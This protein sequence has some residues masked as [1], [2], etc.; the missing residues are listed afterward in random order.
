M[1]PSRTVSSPRT[2]SG[3]CAALRHRTPR[4]YRAIPRL[5]ATSVE[6]WGEA[7]GLGPSNTPIRPARAAPTATVDAEDRPGLSGLGVFNAP[8]YPALQ[9]GL[10]HHGPSALISR[11]TDRIGAA[12]DYASRRGWPRKIPRVLQW[13][14]CCS[15]SAT[16]APKRPSRSR[17]TAEPP[18]GLGLR[19]KAPAFTAFPA[20]VRWRVLLALGSA[21]ASPW[22]KRP[23]AGR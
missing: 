12:K 21:S 15:W 22:I 18:P 19:S 17:R 10:S 20:A 13:Q 9:T 11:R 7:P 6:A 8:G 5:K 1:L 16:R 4:R 3:D 14:A 23:G 2:Q